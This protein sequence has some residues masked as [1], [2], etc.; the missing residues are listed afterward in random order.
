MGRY[1]TA[2]YENKYGTGAFTLALKEMVT[3]TT[4]M[5]SRQQNGIYIISNPGDITGRLDYVVK[6][7]SKAVIEVIFDGT[8]DGPVTLTMRGDTVN[9]Y[10]VDSNGIELSTGTIIPNVIYKILFDG[11]NGKFILLDSYSSESGTLSGVPLADFVRNDVSNIKPISFD[12]GGST[13]TINNNVTV[14]KVDAASGSNVSINITSGVNPGINVDVDGINVGSV[15]YD[16]TNKKW[17][18]NGED[19]LGSQD[20]AIGMLLFDSLN[21]KINKGNTL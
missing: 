18:F 3:K 19:R 13:V 11:V 9:Y 16:I 6:G 7:G 15:E 4:L 10:L 5:A 17:L 2:E 8:N 12:V 20:D 21:N 1:G 14:S